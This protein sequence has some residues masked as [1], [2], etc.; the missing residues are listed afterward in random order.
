M[1]SSDVSSLF[2][3]VPIGKAVKDIQAK[4]RE[5]GSLAE[6]TPLSPDRIAELLDMCLRSTYMVVN[7]MNRERVPP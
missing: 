6:R 4:L 3:N 5:D 2:I 1:V 7:F